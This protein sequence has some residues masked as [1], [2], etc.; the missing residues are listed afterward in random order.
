MGNRG[1]IWTKE[2]DE[3]LLG[4]IKSGRGMHAAASIL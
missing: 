2:D 3:R 4:I 1:K